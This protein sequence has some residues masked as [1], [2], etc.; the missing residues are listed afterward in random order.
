MAIRSA[1]EG[2]APARWIVRRTCARVCH[3]P[4]LW[5]AAATSTRKSICW[6]G[7]WP[8]VVFWSTASG[9]RVTIRTRSS[10]NRRFPIIG[11]KRQSSAKPKLSCCRGSRTCDGAAMRWCWNHPA[12]ARC[13]EF[14]TRKSRPP[15]LHWLHRR[16]LAG[17]GGRTTFRGASFSRCWSIARS[18][19]RSTLHIATAPG[20]PRATTTSFFGTF[21][22]FCSTRAARKAGKPTR[23]VDFIRM[24]A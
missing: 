13:L 6:S 5:P 20:G 8:G 21:T 16:K 18:F 10:S 11:R 22:I 19:S 3:L 17:C 9:A 4:P 14:A 2:S 12:P 23:W 24:P 7:D 1:W 15:S